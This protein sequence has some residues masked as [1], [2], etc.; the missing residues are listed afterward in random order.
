[1]SLKTVELA[2]V[3]IALTVLLAMAHIGGYV[4]NATRQPPVIGE[5]LGGLVLGPTV[6][7]QFAPGA[8]KWLFPSDGATPRFLGAFYSLGMLLLVYLTGT[9]MRRQ[10]DRT[11]QRTVLSVAVSGLALPF[12]FGLLVAREVGLNG[13]AGP[14][15]SP[16]TLA[17][18]FGMAVAITSIP[19]I[20]RIMID[21]GVIDT[22]FAR[23]VLAVAVLED[24]VLYVVLA[25]TLG[26]AQAHADSSYGI[27]KLLGITSV[28]D[29]ITYFT[30]MPLAF[31]VLFLRW[32]RRFFRAL[33]ASRFNAIEVRN[34]VAFRVVFILSMCTACV[35]LGIDP[36]FGALMA[37][38][39]T[40]ESAR[41]EASSADG[42]PAGSPLALR[43]VS[44]AFFVPVYFAIVGLQLD[45][46][47]HLDIG[48]FC[49]FLA[50][51]CLVKSVSVWIGARVAGQSQSSAANIAIAMNARGGPGIVLA[52][53]SYAAGVINENLFTALVLLSL[54]TSQAAGVW[55]GRIVRRGLPLVAGEEELDEADSAPSSLVK[56]PS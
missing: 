55:L 42:S 20:S 43:E 36:V 23:I 45:L 54:I 17:L 56:S 33:V 10:R 16:T 13:L 32:G 1:M 35:G 27:P 18:V 50:F 9:E 41:D 53:T 7:G 39:C 19:V 47:R 49:W 21:L 29:S 4:F 2:H 40:T 51:A 38:L 25:V 3:L 28:A 24:I 8:E 15:G 31:L 48:F 37:G 44:L 46:V 34:P 6:L 14:H 22:A 30:L 5:I 52:S 12:A 11:E 26:I